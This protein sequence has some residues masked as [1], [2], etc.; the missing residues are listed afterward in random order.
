MILGAVI[1]LITYPLNFLPTAMLISI[2]FLLL[3]CIVWFLI[4]LVSKILDIIPF[5]G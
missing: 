2:R 1:R 3:L 4:R 5:A